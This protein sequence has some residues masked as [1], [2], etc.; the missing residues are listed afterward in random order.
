MYVL[1]AVINP[2]AFDSLLDAQ[3]LP[4]GWMSGLVDAKYRLVARLPHGRRGELASDDFRAASTSGGEG[5]YRGRTVDSLDTVIAF[6]H[7]D[8][9]RWAVGLA[10]PSL[11]CFFRR[12][13]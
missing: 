2:T 4:S 3:H 9:S 1:T 12:H 8:F 10:L 6:A 5:W 13:F 7:S 11:D